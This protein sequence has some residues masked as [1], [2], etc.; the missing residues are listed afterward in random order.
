M[1]PKI[2]ALAAWWMTPF[3]EIRNRKG[4]VWRARGR[5]NEFTFA[6]VDLGREIKAKH[7]LRVFNMELKPGEKLGVPKDIKG[8]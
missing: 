1:T 3:S 5:N 2:L 6:H 8:K 4:V 7:D